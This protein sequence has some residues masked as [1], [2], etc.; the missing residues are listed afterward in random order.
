MSYKVNGT[1]FTLQPETG[2]WNAQRS[3]YGTSGG[4]HGIYPRAKTFELKWGFLSASEFNQLLNFYLITSSTGTVV[5]DLPEYGS[6]T[7]Q[8]KSYS[9][10]IIQEPETGSFFEGFYSDVRII[11]NQIITT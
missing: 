8:F 2:Q 3:S 5:M 7:Y 10:T 6:S 11:V 4:G 9:G 1:E